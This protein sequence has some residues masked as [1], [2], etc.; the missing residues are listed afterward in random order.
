MFTSYLPLLDRVLVLLACTS[1]MI[2]CAS[3]ESAVESSPANTLTAAE[4]A[5]GWILL[6]DGASLD[7]WRGIGL[8]TV[9]AGHWTVEDGS[10]R[11]IASGDVPTAPDG[12]PL[13]GGDLVTE[14]TFEN[15]ELVFDWKISPGGNS[16]VKY[17]VSEELS[18][19]HPP[20]YAALG[21]E[22]QVL[23]DDRHE[24]AELASHRAGALYDLL[25]ANDKKQLRPVGE[26]NISRI[27]LD[28]DR[29]EHWLN[30]VQI[31][32]YDLG[33]DEFRERLA[34]SK[35]SDI[36][37]FAERRA[38]H[39]VLQDHSDDVWYRN[40]KIRPIQQR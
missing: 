20:E 25:P 15:F 26:W 4:T 9:P 39:I 31:V 18:R 28:G 35:Y 3:G 34:A 13:V 22:Y 5:E 19:A 21:F 12:Q 38:G 36:A 6:F 1:L 16:G 11:K 24:D 14:A 32:E 30:G 29:G 37:G 10:I 17:N 40:V 27:V 33:S 2:G 8:D 23:D 7:G